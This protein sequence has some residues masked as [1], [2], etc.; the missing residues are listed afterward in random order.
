MLREDTRRRRANWYLRLGLPLGIALVWAAIT[1]AG[2]VGSL[3]GVCMI[4]GLIVVMIGI[5][6]A[7]GLDT[8]G[9]RMLPG[10]N[11]EQIGMERHSS[12]PLPPRW[13]GLRVV[14]TGL[15]YFAAGAFLYWLF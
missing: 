12:E 15:A 9:E 14:V 2:I 5:G 8:A 7:G 3:A 13:A 4:G 10:A 6:M 11:L 1:P